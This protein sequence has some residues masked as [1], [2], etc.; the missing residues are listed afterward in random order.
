MDKKLATLSEEHSAERKEL[1]E[2]HVKEKKQFEVQ[3]RNGQIL[4]V[5]LV[6]IAAA[7]VLKSLK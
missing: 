6:C 2:Q 1:L 4:N 3:I 7:A 5:L